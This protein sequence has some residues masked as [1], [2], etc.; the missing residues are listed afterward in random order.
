ME[1]YVDEIKTFDLSKNSEKRKEIIKFLSDDDIDDLEE[2]EG[3]VPIIKELLR[4]EKEEEL[5][6]KIYEKIVPP[7]SFWDLDFF[8]SMVK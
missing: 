5:R 3:F 6:A 4:F 2:C 1:G 8:T 7:F